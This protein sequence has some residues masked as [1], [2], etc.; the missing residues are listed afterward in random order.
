MKR[1]FFMTM[2]IAM[3]SGPF[4]FAQT[5]QPVCGGSMAYRNADQKCGSYV[6]CQRGISIAVSSYLQNPSTAVMNS[7]A[8]CDKDYADDLY[9]LGICEQGALVYLNTLKLVP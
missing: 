1:L 8:V 7:L 5:E 6:P 2:I 3:S 9:Q 4:A